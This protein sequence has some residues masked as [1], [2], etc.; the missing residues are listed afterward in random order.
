[1]KRH[2]NN[3]KEVIM[4]EFETKTLNLLSDV[5]KDESLREELMANPK[6]VF[7]R[8]LGIESDPDRENNV[9]KEIKDVGYI[10]LPYEPPSDHLGEAKLNMVSEG[11]NTKRDLG[12]DALAR[13]ERM[14]SNMKRR[15]PVNASSTDSYAGYTILGGGGTYWGCGGDSTSATFC[16]LDHN[17]LV[18]TILIAP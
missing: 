1:M 4:T 17:L 13:I 10:V 16:S 12:V 2:A 18:G 6:V 3:R 15:V 7:Q 5:K 11:I 14:R 8:G 9:L